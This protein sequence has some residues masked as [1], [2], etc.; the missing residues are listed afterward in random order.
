MCVPVHPTS[1]HPSAGRPGTSGRVAVAIDLTPLGIPQDRRIPGVVPDRLRATPI[2]A[3]TIVGPAIGPD[4]HRRASRQR[5]GRESI[6]VVRQ[7]MQRPVAHIDRAAPAVGNLHILR[8][9]VGWIV[10]NEHDRHAGGWLCGGRRRCT[11]RRV[12][13]RHSRCAHGRA[14]RCGSAGRCWSRGLSG[15]E[16]QHNR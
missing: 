3:G 8:E 10:F 5:E 15:H 2:E 7:I 11:H 1:P 16:S 9:G 14:G 4:P 6:R 12:S 13:S